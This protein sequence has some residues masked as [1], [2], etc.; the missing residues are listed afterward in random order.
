[1]VDERRKIMS[2]SCFISFKQME[3][4]EIYPFFKELKKKAVEKFEEIATSECHFCPFIR[5]ELYLPDDFMDIPKAKRTEA[6]E[7]A[8]NAVFKHRW[9][10][11]ENLKLLC[12]YSI[13]NALRDMFDQTVNFQNSCDQNYSR[14]DWEGVK[15]LEE[16]YDKW[17]NMSEEE[18]V[19]KYN[20]RWNGNNFA[21]DYQ[22][23]K[24]EW[25]DYY[26]KDFAYEEIWDMFEYTLYD[27]DAVYLSLFNVNGM[28]DLKPISQFV[29]LCYE[30]YKN[31]EKQFEN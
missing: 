22:S 13:P 12:I 10:Y 8:A 26:R 15:A 31:W 25:L 16:I 21:E 11:D 3:A 1:V 30:K 17:M 2:Y 18:I 24:E 4:S 19:A 28:D 29:K 6:K 5:N 20:R 27:K 7:W 23:C 14:E 9:F